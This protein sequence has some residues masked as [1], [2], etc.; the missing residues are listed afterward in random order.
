MA[1]KGQKR[2]LKRFSLPSALRL[3]RKSAVWASKPRPG[4]HRAS[5]CLPL[6]LVVRDYLGLARTAR[7]TGRILAGGQILVDG[8]VRR[9]P[10]FPIGLMDVVQVP[11]I[12]KNYRVLY[13]EKGRLI[14]HEVSQD[15][16]S[17]KLCMVIR[18]SVVKGGRMQL[19]FHD[20]KTSIGEFGEFDLQDVAKL[21]LPDFKVEERLAFEKEVLVLITGG[22]NVGKIGKIQGIQ[23]V[24]EAQ[25]DLITV[26]SDAATFQSPKNY[27]F[28]IGKEKPVISL[29]GG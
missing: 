14:L 24:K 2:H 4:P 8:K 23:H 7:E 13:D 27:V 19:A 22:R 10:K 3:P 17:F 26:K 18:K 21:S 11:K 1:K 20:G 16:A 12:K 15:E 5:E 6:R 28:P 29:P 25:S 9:D